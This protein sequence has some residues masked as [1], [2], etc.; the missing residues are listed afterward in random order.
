MSLKLREGEKRAQNHELD[1]LKE[2]VN[3]KGGLRVGLSKL[4]VVHNRVRKKATA[5][6]EG[7]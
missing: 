1:A 2:M 5:G 7:C 6:S 3:S 4:S